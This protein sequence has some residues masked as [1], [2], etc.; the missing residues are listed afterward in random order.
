MAHT[1]GTATNYLDLLDKLRTFVTTDS[2]LVAAGQAW[3][4]LRWDN[5]ELYLRGPG[6]DGNQ[7]IHVGL[8]GIAY[9]TLDV[10][11]FGLVGAMAYSAGFA[12]AGQPGTSPE[13]YMP[14]WNDAIPYWIVA[15]GQRIVLVAKI[16]T[17]YMACYLGYG[18]PWALPGDYPAA[19]YVGGCTGTITDR[20]SSND[21]GFRSFA[22]P[23]NGAQLLLPSGAWKQ[24]RNYYSYG[25]SEYED[26]ASLNVWPYAGLRGNTSSILK[27][28]R[29]NGDGS[30]TPFPLVLHGSSPSPDIY[31]ELDGCYY[32]TGF[33]NG[34]ET[35]VVIDGVDHLVVPNIFRSDR[36]G[37]WLLRL[38]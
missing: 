23:G 10:Y 29:N 20:W 18:L 9:P 15:N 2:A 21:F 3:M 17:R 5:N 31:M 11:N 13:R 36:W 19:L 27:S 33:G 32:V 38:S 34:A 37:Y 12:F 22:D 30:Y 8:R 26:D 14:L 28:L 7:Q 25:S 35:V 4:Q 6:L 1:T 16:S 24:V